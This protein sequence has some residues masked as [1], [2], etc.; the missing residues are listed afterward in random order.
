MKQPPLKKFQSICTLI[1]KNIPTT[2]QWAWDDKFNHAL[3][4]FNKENL[5]LILLPITLEF[6]QAWDF[7]T[8]DKS[9]PLV[10]AFIQTGF[11]LMPGQNLYTATD[12]HTSGLVLYATCWPW[13]DGDNFSLRVGLFSE[14]PNFPQPQLVKEYLTDWFQIV[15]S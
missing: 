13:G 2:N 4:V 11:G 6:D 5:E 8:L 1:G 9:S 14:D 7:T 10:S 15:E 12:D 3:V